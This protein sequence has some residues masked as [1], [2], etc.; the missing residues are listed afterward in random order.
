M[1]GLL[2]R[3][4]A[5]AERDPEAS[6]LR[7][8]GSETPLLTYAQLVA[9]VERLSA[10]LAE[11]GLE[12][13]E[14]VAL[15]LPS[16]PELLVAFLAVL[17]RGA[18]ALPLEEELT[19]SELSARLEVA[20]PALAIGRAAQLG[21]DTLL[22]LPS[23]RAVVVL[24][25]EQPADLGLPVQ[26]PGEA[27]APLSEPADEDE[28]SCHFTYKGLGYPLGVVH[29]YRDYA[30]ATEALVEAFSLTCADRILSALPLQPIY[31]LIAAGLTPL[32]VGAELV[33]LGPTSPRQLPAL[34]AEE[35]I[36][37]AALVPPLVRLL[38]AAARRASDLPARLDPALVLTSG[39]SYLPPEAAQALSEALQRPVLQGY[40]STE[41]LTVTSNTPS[42]SVLGSLGRPLG[43]AEVE[44]RDA[45]GAPAPT[46]VAGE[47]CVRGPQVMSGYLRRPRE[48]AR[49][50]RGGWLRTGD[51]GW[52]DEE[53]ALHFAGRREAFTKVNARMVDLLEVEQALSA[54]PAVT[55]ACATTR[56]GRKGEREL[57]VAV[58][59]TGN[60][61]VRL[62]ELLSLA[63][64]RLA[65]HKVPKRIK[66]YRAVYQ[67]FQA[68]F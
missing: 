10:A 56:R 55:R 25:E 20:E 52:L 61:S 29:R 9:E 24:G 6:A 64:E 45:S 42:H 54:H 27:R 13:G 40:G 8:A 3:I 17:A 46:G 53:G 48:T 4:L 38:G 28:V 68:E 62:G 16:G 47:V 5:H 60:A 22:S 30:L 67:G 43:S 65:P 51:L 41:A 15:L 39:G 50:L 12:R 63:K 57:R 23:L 36:R 21:R 37:A 18:L 44:V 19:S 32:V 33:F 2:G 7:A 26:Q 49:F 1:S 35:R 59:L 66:V 31:G 34:L 58:T 14:L 11:A